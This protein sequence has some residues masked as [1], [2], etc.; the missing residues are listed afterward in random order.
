[1][2]RVCDL[3]DLPTSDLFKNKNVVKIFVGKIIFISIFLSLNHYSALF[4]FFSS[5]CFLSKIV[6][7]KHSL[8]IFY[9]N[10]KFRVHLMEKV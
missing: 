4:M 2:D 10:S 6:L 7:I 8:C 1:M 3:V 9:L 5:I